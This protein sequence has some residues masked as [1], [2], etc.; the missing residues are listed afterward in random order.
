MVNRPP[1]ALEVTEEAP[2]PPGRPAPPS[3]SNTQRRLLLADGTTALLRRLGPGDRAIVRHMHAD[4]PRDDL[5]R[6]FFDFSP[7][8]GD[9]AADATLSPDSVA[10]GL[11]CAGELQGVANFRGRP[12][13]IAMAVARSAQHHGVG[14]LLLEALIE[15]ARQRDIALLVAEVLSTNVAMLQVLHDSRAP[16]ESRCDGPT[17]HITIHIP[18]ATSGPYTEA[19][20]T[21]HARAER[22]SLRP[23][24]R[25]RSI[26]LVGLGR[27][28]RSIGAVVLEQLRASGFAGPIYLVRPS[29]S[30]P[31]DAMTF[32]S[33]DELPLP[34]DL[35]VLC[36]PAEAVPTAVQAC[37]RRGI[38]AVVV[39]S[40]GITDRPAVATALAEAVAR[41]GIRL[42]GPNCIG[43]AN[44]D[45]EV[46]LSANFLRR[47]PAGS[48][49]VATQ[50][51][52]VAVAVTESLGALGLGVSTLVSTGDST[53]VRADD[54]MLWWLEDEQTEAAVLYTESL[55]RP[56]EYASIAR[57]LARRIPILTVRPARSEAARVAAARHSGA[58][59]DAPGATDALLEEAGILAVD[60]LTELPE[61]LALLIGQP[62]PSGRTVAIVTNAGGAG[63]LAAEACRNHGLDLAELGAPLAEK[64]RALLP[65]LAS[66]GN[67]TDTSAAVSAEDYRRVVDT[68]VADPGVDAVI[69]VSAPLATGDPLAGLPEL[70]PGPCPVVAVRL[71]QTSAVS[72]LATSN[73]GRIPVYADPNAASRALARAARRAG[74]LRRLEQLGS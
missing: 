52:G 25:P 66:V 45:L 60:Q 55:R 50:S 4:L 3:T 58:P 57:Q 41:Y 30:H 31:P 74:W 29:L 9:I 44:T 5:Y 28:P 46:A 26:A 22:A 63:V 16:M 71:G 59:T 10:V 65:P 64:L 32:R 42:V 23:L 8:A 17:T 21:R 38:P 73:H 54:L 53:D 49:G 20:I 62:L 35:V 24:L 39:I 43:I 34:V 48:V 19:E 47:V 27:H 67:P 14:T 72:L 2:P 68:L 36:V 70:V 13:E 12:P 33:I 6:R 15:E 37:G 61:L 18:P 7:R 40:S 56:G 11:F 1:K 69:A 51:G